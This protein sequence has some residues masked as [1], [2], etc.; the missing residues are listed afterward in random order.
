MIK[1]IGIFPHPPVVLPE[2]GGN[3]YLKVINTYKA[4]EELAKEFI[5][6]GIKKLI[7]IS[8]HGPVYSRMLGVNISDT[9]QGDLSQFDYLKKY[10][11]KNNLSLAKEL[12]ED[13]FYPVKSNLD[14]GVLVPLYFFEKLD[15]N[16]EVVSISTGVMG[17]DELLE[18][19]KFIQNLLNNGESYKDEDYGIVVSADLSH[20]LKEDSHYGFSEDGP[21]F[22]KMVY[23]YIALGKM[24]KIKEIPEDIVD[25]A[26]QCGFN[27]LILGSSAIQGLNVRT[28]VFSYEK[29]FGVGYLIGKGDVF[30]EK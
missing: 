10:I 1:K 12:V 26:G 25:G 5:Q 11:F 27:P 18:K 17:I 9:L 29:P 7:V 15:H 19:G 6:S 2:I 22:D 3:E 28:E 24:E 4:M 13:G 14:H 16:L 30:Y 21:I 23:D 20:R 8:P